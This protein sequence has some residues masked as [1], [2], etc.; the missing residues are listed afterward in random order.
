VESAANASPFEAANDARRNLDKLPLD[1]K[2]KVVDQ[3]AEN[4]MAEKLS[5]APPLE[6]G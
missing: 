1:E 3:M 5:R 6:S 4:L 2:L